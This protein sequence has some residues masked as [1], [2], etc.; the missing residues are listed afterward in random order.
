MLKK[1][2]AA[3]KAENHISILALRVLFSYMLAAYFFSDNLVCPPFKWKIFMKH[4][5][6][7]HYYGRKTKI[8]LLLKGIWLHKTVGGRSVL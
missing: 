7:V 2:H 5:D 6:N 8:A 4:K 3:S 1:S